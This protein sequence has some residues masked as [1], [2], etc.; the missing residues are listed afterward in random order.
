MLLGITTDPTDIDITMAA[1]PEKLWNTIKKSNTDMSIFRTDKFWTITLVRKTRANKWEQEEKDNAPLSYEYEITPFRTEWNYSDARHP[2]E[3]T[4]SKNLLDDSKRRDLT[5]NSM[6]RYGYNIKEGKAPVS[7][8]KTVKL[9]NTQDIVN[10]LK[11]HKNLYLTDTQT[12][13]LQ[14]HDSIQKLFKDGHFQETIFLHM[15]QNMH[16]V[17]T[18]SQG[19]HTDT[20]EQTLKFQVSIIIDPFQGLQD[21]V[22][23]KIRTVGNP[24]N[25]F[26]EDA[27]R[28]LRW[29]RFPIIL[30]Q[31]IPDKEKQNTWFTYNKETRSSMLDHAHLVSKL[32]KERIHQ[33]LVK[34]FSSNNPFGYIALLDELG[35][36]ETLFPKLALCKQNDQPTLY[37][38]FDTYTHTLLTLHALQQLKQNKLSGERKSPTRKDR[39][40]LEWAYSNPLPYFAM[41]YHDIGKPEQ[42]K[43]ISEQVAKDPNNIDM[44]NYEHHTQTGVN[45]TNKDFQK[46][47]FSN[48][49]REEITRYIRRHHRPGEILDSNKKNRDKKLRQLLSE[50]WRE[51]TL[52]LIDITIADRLGQYNPLQAPAVAQLYEMKQKI[53]KLYDAEGRFT[54]KALAINGKDLIKEFDLTPWPP[55]GK[56]LDK[57]FDRVLG[58]IK[59]RNN[60]KSILAH[61]KSLFTNEQKY[62]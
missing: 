2:D 16:T 11:Q 20:S 58:D 44:D 28:I 23:R 62:N 56:L 9:K 10:K 37:H 54:L 49:E 39:E 32:A 53:K 47:W 38:P 61:I 55:L 52:H 26:T 27:L 50:W 17:S 4:R 25:R 48:K 46:L 18:P 3:I 31:Y 42:Y 13:I 14:D 57:A 19:F 60:K 59:S 30:N 33:E 6:Y 21:L 1:N 36:I 22:I 29:V 8:N 41:L 35:L 45:M 34:V 5:I 15:L 12:L 51:R 43:Y 40:T 24:D 7:I